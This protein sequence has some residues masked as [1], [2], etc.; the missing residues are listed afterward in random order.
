MREALED[1]MEEDGSPEN[2]QETQSNVV[3]N[4]QFCSGR[5]KSLVEQDQS[6]FDGP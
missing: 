4:L 5:G 6:N 1:D 2:H 3:N